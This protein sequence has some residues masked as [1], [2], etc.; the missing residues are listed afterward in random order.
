MILDNRVALGDF[1]GDNRITALGPGHTNKEIGERRYTLHARV[2]SQ[3]S[4]GFTTRVHTRATSPQYISP[5]NKKIVE[6]IVAAEEIQLYYGHKH[7]I[8]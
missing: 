5:S 3:H 6:R 4:A 1:C 2:P 7:S 8:D